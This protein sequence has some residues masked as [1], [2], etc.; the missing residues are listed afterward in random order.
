MTQIGNTQYVKVYLCKAS[1]D[2]PILIPE[3]EHGHFF[4]NAVYLVDVKG[5]KMR[6]LIQ[7]FGPRMA[8][9]KVSEF[10]RFMAVL[11]EGMYIPR[12]IMRVSMQQGH[13]DDTILK[14]FPNGFICHDGNHT[15][16]ANKQEKIKENGCMYKIMGP[17]GEQPHAVEQDVVECKK[18]NSNEAF[19]VVAKGGDAAFYWLGS[20]ASEDEKAFAKTLGAVLA[21]SASVNTGFEEGSESDEFWAALGGK[22]EYPSAKELGFAPGFEPRLFHLTNSQGYYYMKEIYNYVQDDLNNNDIMALDAYKTIFIWVGIHANKHEKKN[23]I[24]KVEKFIDALQDGRTLKSVQIVEIEPCSEP[25][26]FTCNF[27]EW[28][29]EVAD[30]W[31]QPDPYTALMQQIE[32]DRAES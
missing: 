10:R 11:T 2:A 6:Y 24:S 17:F 16:I 14:L 13:E 23:A 32:A 29:D 28:E 21:P 9:D 7:W 22:T 15:E 30:K 1:E 18:L 27:P 20:G 4:Q 8:G 3:T 12:E 26:T 31:L 25:A 5:D 19:V